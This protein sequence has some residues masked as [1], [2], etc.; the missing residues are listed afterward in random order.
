MGDVRMHHTFI[1][2]GKESSIRE[3][4]RSGAFNHIERIS[5]A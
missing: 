3:E 1:R 4:L 2:D 5:V